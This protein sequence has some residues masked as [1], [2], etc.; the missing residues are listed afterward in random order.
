MFWSSSGE[1]TDNRVG[2][3]QGESYPL[4]LVP[5]HM[6]IL[7]RFDSS[8]KPPWLI[9]CTSAPA[10]SNMESNI[11]AHFCRLYPIPTYR[12]AAYAEIAGYCQARFCAFF[13]FFPAKSASVRTP[14]QSVFQHLLWTRRSGHVKAPVLVD[15]RTRIRRLKS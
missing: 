14:G 13:G 8:V 5:P 6:S 7:T 11:F 12:L 3:F 1:S 2:H 4:L 9:H 10:G 15:T